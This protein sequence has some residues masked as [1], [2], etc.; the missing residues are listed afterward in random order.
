[1]KKIL[2]FILCAMLIFALPVVAFAEGTSADGIV[3]G[4]LVEENSTITNENVTEGENSASEILIISDKIVSWILA[5]IEEIAVVV[6]NAIFAIFFKRSYAK[7][8]LTLG[9]VNN[10][11]VTMAKDS[12][13]IIDKALVSINGAA[14]KVT[15]YE[16]AI[17]E[18]LTEFRSNA[19]EKLKLEGELTN[20]KQYLE[21]AK[22]ANVELANEVAELLCLANIP[23]S[24]KDE[25]YSRHRAAV[26]KIAEADNTEVKKDDGAEA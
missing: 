1:M 3:Q 20:I 21:S 11:A 4:G 7:T 24:K 26:G 8:N 18:L 25:L 2:A 14:A 22:L 13:N 17:K 10:N 16:D 9:T 15:G 23:V 19:E 5:H 12:T 6:F